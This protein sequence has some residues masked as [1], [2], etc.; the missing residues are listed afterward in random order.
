MRKFI[1]IIAVVFSLATACT[2]NQMA[3][4]YGGAETVS[5]PAGQK[6]LTATWKGDELWYVTEPMP[7][8]YTPTNKTFQEKSQ[9]GL[10]EGKVVF[11]ESR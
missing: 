1:F 6:L 5:L 10:M 11:V 9:Y 3:R 8:D 2:D 4:K 7:E